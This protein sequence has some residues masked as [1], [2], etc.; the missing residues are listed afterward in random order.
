MHPMLIWIACDDYYDICELFVLFG[1][2]IYAI[3]KKKIQ[4]Q[5]PLP[6][7]KTMAHGKETN[8]YRV[9]K[10]RHTANI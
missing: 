6:C 10:P 9:P 5:G 8:V 7:A 3:N 2:P 1:G 4:D